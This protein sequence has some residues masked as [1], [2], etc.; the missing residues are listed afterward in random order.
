MSTAKAGAHTF[1]RDQVLA[2]GRRAWAGNPASERAKYFYD[3]IE[4]WRRGKGSKRRVLA[5]AATPAAGWWH[6]PECNCGLCRAPSATSAAAPAVVA[7]A[8]AVK[9]RAE[10]E[11]DLKDWPQRTAIRLDRPR[12]PVPLSLAQVREVGLPALFLDYGEALLYL[13]GDVFDVDATRAPMRAGSRPIPLP[14]AILA[15]GVGIDYG[16]HHAGDCAC[17]FCSGTARNERSAPP[18]RT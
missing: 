8:V 3:G 1:T 7:D 2:A 9:V 18:C 14:T 5:G 11:T 10:H 4:F 6:K 12:S 15:R 16:W 17:R 13:E